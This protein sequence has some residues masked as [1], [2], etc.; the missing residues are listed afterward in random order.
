RAW[1][2]HPFK[3][4]RRFFLA[5]RARI[6][7]MDDKPEAPTNESDGRA[8]CSRCG[9]NLDDRQVA[10]SLRQLKDLSARLEARLGPQPSDCDEFVQ[11][12]HPYCQDCFAGLERLMTPE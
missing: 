8:R 1:G 2:Y 7:G 4:A 12:S 10:A 6:R 3:L 5:P 11:S 9:A